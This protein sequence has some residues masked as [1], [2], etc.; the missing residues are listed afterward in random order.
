MSTTSHSNINL[1]TSE[2]EVQLA[3]ELFTLFTDNYRWHHPGA[4]PAVAAMAETFSSRF[5]TAMAGKIIKNGEFL[6]ETP[7]WRRLYDLVASVVEAV[8]REAPE[9]TPLDS[10]RRDGQFIIILTH[11]IIAFRAKKGIHLK[12]SG[13]GVD[14]SRSRRAARLTTDPRALTEMAEDIISGRLLDDGTITEDLMLN[15][16]MPIAVAARLARRWRGVNDF[17]YE[18]CLRSDATPGILDEWADHSNS[19]VLQKIASHPNSTLS[20]LT[21]LAENCVHQSVVAAALSR[22]SPGELDSLAERLPGHGTELL[23]LTML[24]CPHASDYAKTIAALM[25]GQIRLV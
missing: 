1:D 10:M 15:T 16:N 9:A 14:E 2:L 19:F 6:S 21:K 12:E 11:F 23:R 22:M 17:G 4:T 20:T 25:T 7:D 18:L 8:F 5:S 24:Q 13:W 3:S